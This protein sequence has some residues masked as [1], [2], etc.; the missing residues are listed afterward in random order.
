MIN[1]IVNIILYK[2]NQIYI[3][4]CKSSIEN[5]FL[6]GDDII[7][8]KNQLLWKYFILR[9]PRFAIY[10]FITNY[11]LSF[12]Y[13]QNVKT[14]ELFPKT[15]IKHFFFNF[16]LRGA[17]NCHRPIFIVVSIT[18]LNRDRN[19]I[20]RHRHLFDGS[21]SSFNYFFLFPR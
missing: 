12:L 13:L 3:F 6:I 2:T 18:V 15:I 16:T 4:N 9:D 10:F 1:K 20:N 5:V 19:I 21:E 8:W 17:E 11:N 14:S 7:L